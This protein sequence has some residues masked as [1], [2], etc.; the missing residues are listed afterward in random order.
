MHSFVSTFY[1][2]RLASAP[3]PVV[4][5]SAATDAIAFAARMDREADALLSE[6]RVW[7]AERLAHLALEARCRATGARA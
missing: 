5:P 7:Q 2:R 6:G 3:V 1:G 4:I